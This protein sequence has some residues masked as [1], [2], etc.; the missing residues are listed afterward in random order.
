MAEIQKHWLSDI[1]AIE[2]PYYQIAQ[3]NSTEFN[4]NGDGMKLMVAKFPLGDFS[5]Y[6]QLSGPGTV[7]FEY[8]LSPNGTA[9]VAPSSPATIIAGVATGTIAFTGFHPVL[10]PWIGIRA[11][12]KNV[13]AVNFEKLVLYYH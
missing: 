5:L 2:A 13:G 3:N 8:F 12:E 11:T 6:Y 9:I 7:D 4:D 10:S 1:A